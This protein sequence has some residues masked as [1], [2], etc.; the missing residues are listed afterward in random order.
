MKTFDGTFF[1]S[2][3]ALVAQLT[4][5]LLLAPMDLGSDPVVTNY[6]IYYIARKV[7]N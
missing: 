5:C 6:N 2:R 7:N 4:E 3:A 1:I